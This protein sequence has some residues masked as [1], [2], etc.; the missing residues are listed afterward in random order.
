M[1][2]YNLALSSAQATG[3]FVQEGHFGSN[4]LHNINIDSTGG[5]LPHDGFAAAVDQLDLRH[6]R[7]PGG[8]AEN[9][10]DVTKLEGGELRAE[11]RAFMDWCVANSTPDDK[12][13]VTVVL[14]TKVDI[15]AAQVET[16]VYKLLEDYGDHVSGLEIGNEYSIGQRV[17][18]AD[19]SIHPEENPDSDFVSSMNETEYGIAANRVINAA[20]S[21]IDKLAA[22]RPA[23]D[24]DPDI[25]IQLG[26]TNGAGSAY[27]G[28]GSWDQANEAILSWLDQTAL[29]A[30]DGAVAHY[31]YNKPHTGSLAFDGGY[32]EIRSLDHR[33]ENFNSHLGRDVPLYVTEWNVLKSNFDQLGMASASTIL[34]MFESMVQLGTAEAFIWPLQHRT[35]NTIGGNRSA[36]DLDLSPAGGV[37]QMMSDNLRPETSTET[38]HVEAFQSM[39]TTWSGTG[40]GSVEINYF[41]SQYHDVLYVSHRDLAT[42]TLNVDLSAFTGGATSID[43]TRMTLDRSSSDGLSDLADDNGL[44]RLS[45]R[46]IDAAEKA[47]LEDLAFFDPSNKNHI[48]SSGDKYLTYLPDP[49][50]IVPL[51][52]APDSID[53][54]YFATEV[55]VSPQFIDLPGDYLNTG[56]VHLDVMP[57][58]VTQI[59]IEKTWRQEGGDANERFTGGVGQ[60]L[61]LGRSGN[62]TISTGEGNDTLKGG[63]G[64]DILYG[65][66]G[67]DSLASGFGNDSLF[68]GSGND[69]ISV[70]DGIKVIDGGSGTDRLK[71]DLARSAYTVT[72]D[73]SAVRL[74]ADGFDARI[75]NVETFQFADQT[76]SLNDVLHGAGSNPSGFAGGTP[77]N[78]VVG[79][80]TGLFGTEESAQV[81]RA[82]AT[83]LGREPDLTAHQHWTT[84]LATGT[85]T[86]DE[87]TS[88][89]TASAEFQSLYGGTSNSQFVT[90]LYHTALGRGP[91]AAEQATWTNQL[92][93][94]TSRAELVSSLS[95]SAEHIALTQSG[96]EAFDLAH[97]PTSWADDVVRLYQAIFDRS[98]DN[99]GF[100]YWTEQLPNGADFNQ[101]VSA[102]MN[103]PE[104]Q[105][106]Y[107]DA[108]VP[109]FVELL[110]QNVL[111]RGAD[112]GGTNFWND[113]LQNNWT[114]PDV[115][116]FFMNSREFTAKMAPE[117]KAYMHRIGTDD[118]LQAAPGNSI[119]SGG[120]YADTFVFENTDDGR[121]TITDLEAWDTL[122]F[123]QFGYGSVNDALG[124]M[125]QQGDDVVF[126]DDG[127]T[128]VINDYALDQITPDMIS[129][130]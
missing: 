56:S 32:Q 58:D 9:T 93:A 89:L 123:T 31:Y 24:H 63:Y 120:L 27:K 57:Y 71:L 14:P 3:T 107:G 62:D 44:N 76:Q 85:M 10:L 19:R 42:G 78:I 99:G 60:D 98:P 91:S 61:V 119:L 53:D 106:T 48:K 43:V 101:I 38:G 2:S 102:F 72:T 54:Y 15:P 40:G 87:V 67:D 25:L 12:I 66:S 16:F 55:D 5:F 112:T 129:I 49:D 23:L 22:D 117:V 130:L 96:Q 108:T 124:Q 82:F 84:Q 95:Q 113:A 115:V 100:A 4:A 34:E 92:S 18:N 1:A 68:A 70:N 47:A 45:R 77:T 33:I 35:A 103:S 11:V 75:E 121:H 127:V 6:L 97:D 105:T 8:H 90:Q 83:A 13:Q 50:T 122:Q 74:R 116:T 37:F 20:Q 110:Y 114:R 79:E 21:A 73:G 26:D 29:D 59:V 30:I 7:Y 28:N 88:A 111:K 17:A 51:T 125:S 118:V 64:N 104:F 52:N 126:Q 41:A 94:G 46:Y 109:E 80:T 39:D 65:G 69:T 81:Y 36:T 86:L 128:V